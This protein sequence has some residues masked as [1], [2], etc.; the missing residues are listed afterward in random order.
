MGARQP[1]GCLSRKESG[2]FR[3]KGKGTDFLIVDFSAT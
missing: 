2:G 1:S 3:E